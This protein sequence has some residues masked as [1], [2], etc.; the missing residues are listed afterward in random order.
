MIEEALISGVVQGGVAGF[1]I[2][3]T[4]KYVLPKL[5]KIEDKVTEVHT[6]VQGCKKKAKV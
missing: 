5:D 6:L 2:F 3:M 1:T 4:F